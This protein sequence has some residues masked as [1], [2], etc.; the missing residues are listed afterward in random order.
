[1]DN[2]ILLTPAQALFND[3]RLCSAISQVY[4]EL[5]K[6]FHQI[7]QNVVREDN[8]KDIAPVIFALGQIETAFFRLKQ[9]GDPIVERMKKSQQNNTNV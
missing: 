5:E 6:V 3:E 9:K 1:M 2:Q 7:Q 8:L 4:P